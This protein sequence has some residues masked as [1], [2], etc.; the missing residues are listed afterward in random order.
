MIFKR[1]KDHIKQNVH[2]YIDTKRSR[3]FPI[4]EQCTWSSTGRLVWKEYWQQHILWTF[5]GTYSSFLATLFCKMQ[6]LW[7]GQDMARLNLSATSQPQP[8]SCLTV[9]LGVFVA[10][11]SNQVWGN[12]NTCT[13]NM[14]ANACFV[15]CSWGNGVLLQCCKCF[16]VRFYLWKGW[17]Y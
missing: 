10:G 14:K 8:L 16:Y 11:I 13:G 1:D 12:P 3:S 4:R 17:H 6:I 15:L 7:L 9:A 2:H 5:P